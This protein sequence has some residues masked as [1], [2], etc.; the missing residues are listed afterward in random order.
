M[1]DSCFLEATLGTV[2][3]PDS[4]ASKERGSW[5]VSSGAPGGAAVLQGRSTKLSD[6]ITAI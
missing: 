5:H 6:V 3:L 1:K 2:S 4:E